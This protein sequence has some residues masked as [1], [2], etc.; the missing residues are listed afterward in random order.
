MPFWIF[1]WAASVFFKQQPWGKAEEVT[2]QVSVRRGSLLGFLPPV[3][4]QCHWLIPAQPWARLGLCLHFSSAQPTSLLVLCTPSSHRGGESHPP[5]AAE[6][7]S[8][9][10]TRARVWPHRSHGTIGLLL[11]MTKSCACRSHT[12]T[13]LLRET[14]ATTNTVPVV[15]YLDTS[16]VLTLYLTITGSW[17]CLVPCFALVNFCQLVW[18]FSISIAPEDLR[19]SNP[20][21]LTLE[22]NGCLF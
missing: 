3:V 11:M 6:V 19:E 15:P 12:A 7:A 8:T 14:T 5:P 13:L 4:W 16:S 17:G 18:A 20:E 1:Q 21:D 10:Q 2:L 9:T 22:Q